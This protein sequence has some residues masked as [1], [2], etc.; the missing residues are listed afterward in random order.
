M[1]VVASTKKGIR[2]LRVESD[3]TIYTAAELKQEFL[4]GLAKCKELELDLSGV[5]EMDSAGL[6]LL[7]LLKREAKDRGVRLHMVAHGPA[8]TSVIDTCNMAAFFG[9]PIVLQTREVA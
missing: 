9:D 5:N 4:P 7:I 3:M 1:A 6:Q 8:V 2:R